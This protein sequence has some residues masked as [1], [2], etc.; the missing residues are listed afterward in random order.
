[1]SV[2]RLWQVAALPRVIHVSTAKM[3]GFSRV[4][5]LN[6][7]LPDLKMWFDVF[8]NVIHERLIKFETFCMVVLS[9][10]WLL[11]T[12]TFLLINLR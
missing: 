7:N 11:Y 1:M 2:R 9:D 10:V 5:A 6:D 3:F 4:I 8:F 12:H